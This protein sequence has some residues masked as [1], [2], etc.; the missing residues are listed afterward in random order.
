MGDG[1]G[2]KGAPENRKSRGSKVG[3]RRVGPDRPERWGSERWGR[4]VGAERWG[5]K[6]WGCEGEGEGTVGSQRGWGTKLSPFFFPFPATCS[7]SSSLEGL[8]VELWPRSPNCDHDEAICPTCP[9]CRL[10]L[11]ASHFS[12]PCLPWTTALH[13]SLTWKLMYKMRFRQFH[14]PLL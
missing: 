13:H 2:P 10:A 9:E 5:P 6:G 4:K 3:A 8:L 14:N 7:M 1:S 11:C 12:T